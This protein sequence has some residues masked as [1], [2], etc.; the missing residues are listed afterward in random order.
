MIEKFEKY[1]TIAFC[2]SFALTMGS[3]VV[4]AAIAVFGGK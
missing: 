3:I 1:I 2:V 4:R